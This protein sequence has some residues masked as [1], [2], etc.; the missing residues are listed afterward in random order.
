MQEGGRFTF[1]C[2]ELFLISCKI[3]L[4]IAESKRNVYDR[5]GKEGLSGGGGGGGGKERSVKVSIFISLSVTLGMK[6][7]HTSGGNSCTFGICIGALTA[8]ND[9]CVCSVIFVKVRCHL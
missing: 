2:S 1:S 6:C 9:S 8:C 4:S 7:R 3:L 5:Y